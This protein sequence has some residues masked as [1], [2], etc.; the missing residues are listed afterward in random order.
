MAAG[1]ASGFLLDLG[2]LGRGVFLDLHDRGAGEILLG[3]L[4]V[5][6]IALARMGDCYA[7]PGADVCDQSEQPSQ[8]ACAQIPR[9]HVYIPRVPPKHMLTVSMY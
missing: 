1:C 2:C 3:V 6:L 4:G 9:M 5:I 7:D 8:R